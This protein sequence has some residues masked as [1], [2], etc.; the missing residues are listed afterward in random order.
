MWQNL[1]ED[2]E[3]NLD[4]KALVP[5]SV[6]E[7]EAVR[8]F[9]EARKRAKRL[10]DLAR[11]FLDE[12]GV[13]VIYAVFGWLNWI[14]ESRPPMPGED[15]IELNGK[16][17][18]KV[19]SPLLFVPITLDLSATSIRA[20][21]EENAVIE[22]NLALESFLEQQLRIT[23]GFDPDAELAPQTVLN[24]WRRAINAREHWSIEQGEAVLIDSFSFRKIALLRE[25]DRATERVVDQP[26]LR[27]FC[28]DAE[29]LREAPAVPSYNDLDDAVSSEKTSWCRPMLRRQ[30]LS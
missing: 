28:G 18:R 1:T 2:G 4:R 26:V 3:I 9:E 17:V 21:F 20:K 12:Q 23:I 5:S 13:H 19:R 8:S 11:T 27:A 25:L 30:G 16:K 22:T 7:M 24:A 6:P 14:D 29:Q 15:S 10:S